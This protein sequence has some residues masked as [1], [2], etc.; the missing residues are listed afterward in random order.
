MSSSD[1]L[2]SPVSVGRW[3]LVVR[4]WSFVVRPPAVSGGQWSVVGG[5][6]QYRTIVGIRKQEGHDLGN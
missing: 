5:R 1:L 4:H 6:V 3:P 2:P